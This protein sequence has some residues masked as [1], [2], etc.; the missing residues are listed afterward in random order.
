MAESEPALAMELSGVSKRFGAVVALERVS[1][2]IRPGT[3]HALLGENGAGKTTLMRIAYGM[4]P[5]DAGTIRVGGVTQRLRAPSDA[6]AAGIGMVHQH[7]TLVPAMTVGE[8]IALGGRGLHLARD[9]AARVDEVSR[10]TGFALDA[11][12]LVSTLSVGAQQRVEIAKALA[13]RARVL[14]LDEPT[15]VLAPAEIDDLL[16]WLR[17]YVARGNAAVLITHKLREALAVADDV[18]VL[19]R[20]SLVVTGRAAEMSE[21]S[22]TNA[23]LGGALAVTT[24][25]PRRRATTGRPVFRAGEMTVADSTGRVRVR[26]ASFTISAGELV[27]VVGVE[28][29]GQREL[30]RALAGRMPIA[31]GSLVRPAEVGFVPED[32]HHDA[33]LLARPLSENVALRGAGA[34]RGMMR[35]PAM[36]EATRALMVAFDVQA[37]GTETSMATLSGGNQQ[38]LVLARELGARDAGRRGG[39]PHQQHDE[40]AGGSDHPTIAPDILAT[41]DAIVVE[42]PT[43]GLDVRATAD[44][45]ER[46]RAAA[47]DG[48]AVIVYSSDLDEVLALA[49]RV[50]VV[51]DGIVRDMAPDRA[52]I[53]QA[54]L[55]VD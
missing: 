21:A 13:R 19:R 51:F 42:N 46:L 18:T 14:V 44:L 1:L 39:P 53:G 43:R 6:I 34:R 4:I 48:A 36:R 41:P 24:A 29:S 11:A 30:L 12:A 20:G 32:R 38:K 26:A 33:V 3:V 10:L 23:M 45:H 52:A 2:A 22:L 31:S 37:D 50:L 16:A 9:A 54:M 27:G 15:G 40:D 28:G 7:F 17:R 55:G 47:T 5:P 8:N 25:G 49:G 35:W